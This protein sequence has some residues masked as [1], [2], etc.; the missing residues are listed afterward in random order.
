MSKKPEH[1]FERKTNIG[2]FSNCADIKPQKEG[3]NDAICEKC[4]RI[5]K[6]NKNE[7][8]CPNCVEKEDD[9]KGSD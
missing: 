1:L 8:I 6:T 7:Y 9:T 5:F 3:F 4:E 2:P